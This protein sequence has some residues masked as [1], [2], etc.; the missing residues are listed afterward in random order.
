MIVY[1]VEFIGCILL[2]F[3]TLATGNP[4]AMGIC[5]ALL[6][7]LSNAAAPS[8]FNPAVT[9]A[10]TSA[11]QLPNEHLLGVILCQMF[12]GLVGLEIYRRYGAQIVKN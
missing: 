8:Y 4:L 5:W 12:G 2:M 7:L 1:L 6:I 11:G 9:M 10:M 3:V